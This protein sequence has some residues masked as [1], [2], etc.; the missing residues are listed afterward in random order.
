MTDS[1]SED[2]D[3]NEISDI[4]SQLTELKESYEKKINELQMEFSELKGLMMAFMNK[5]SENIPSSSSLFQ[6]LSKQP[7]M[8]LDKQTESAGF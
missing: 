7:R 3:S 2:S 5:Q 1:N 8:G 6:G 4:S